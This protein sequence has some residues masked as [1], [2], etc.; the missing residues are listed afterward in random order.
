MWLLVA[1]EGEVAESQEN[2]GVHQKEQKETGCCL[3]AAQTGSGL[4]A[5]TS[6]LG[7]IPDGHFSVALWQHLLTKILASAKETA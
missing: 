6:A 1:A 5:N 3:G 2:K 4:S 7:Y